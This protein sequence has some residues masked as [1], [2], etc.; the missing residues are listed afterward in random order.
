MVQTPDKIGHRLN[1]SFHMATNREVDLK[2]EV[3][4]ALLIILAAP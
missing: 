4:I 3:I 2:H 1:H